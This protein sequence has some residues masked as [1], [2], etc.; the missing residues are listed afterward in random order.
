M[1]GGKW[2]YVQYR[3]TDVIDD[4][5]RLIEKNGKMK[6]EQEMKDEGWSDPFWY[7]KYPEDKYH[8][9]YPDEVIE[10]F[11][12]AI[13][14]MSF[15]QVYTHRIDWLLSGDDGEETFINRLTED[16]KKIT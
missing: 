14:F 2:E 9:R 10:E 7:D 12:R 11:E 6:T 8:H 5:R 3:F 1:S 15:A 13:I 4:L 16:I